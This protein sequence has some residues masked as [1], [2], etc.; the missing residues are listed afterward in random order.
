MIIVGTFQPSIEIERAL[1]EIE[2]LGILP[3]EMMVLYMD[4]FPPKSNKKK[5]SA[6]LH[7]SS[8]EIGIA[9]ATGLAVI[10]ASVGFKLVVGP[11]FSGILAAIIGFFSGYCLYLFQ[12]KKK[13]KM[14]PS[15]PEIIVLIQSSKEDAPII[16]EILWRNKAQSVGMRKRM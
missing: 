8:F 15:M 2:E 3:E 14:H 7:V 6:D 16:K 12:R 11:I 1:S 13:N 5:D 4:E 9:F 10:G